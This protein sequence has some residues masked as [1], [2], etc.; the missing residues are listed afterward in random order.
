MTK[1]NRNISKSGDIQYQSSFFLFRD[2]IYINENNR[3]KSIRVGLDD[4]IVKDT[5]MGYDLLRFS[6]YKKDSSKLFGLNVLKRVVISE[7]GNIQVD[8]NRIKIK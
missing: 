8:G 1:E 6:K 7:T 5:F 2:L 4:R 3:I